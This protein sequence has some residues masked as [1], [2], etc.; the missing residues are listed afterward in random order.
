MERCFEAPTTLQ[1][2][3]LT[4]PTLR[5]NEVALAST[6][7]TSQASLGVSSH[8]IRGAHL[9]TIRSEI[10]YVLSSPHTRTCRLD[11]ASGMEQVGD[12]EAAFKKWG[13]AQLRRYSSISQPLPLAL[14]LDFTLFQTVGMD[15]ASI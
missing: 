12:L 7:A 14:A 11:D 1:V 4:I 2:F 9:P 5:M 10:S 13:A 15:N 3:V 8:R 6:I